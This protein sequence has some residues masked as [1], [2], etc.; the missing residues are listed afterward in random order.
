M[1]E[2][3]TS[4]RIVIVG[5]GGFGREMLDVIEAINSAG[6]NLEFLGFVDDGDVDVG[7][8]RHRQ[9]ALLGQ[10]EV[11][12]D[13]DAMYI[14]GIGNG[15]VRE[16][17]SARFDELG[18][19][20]A[21]LVH[22]SATVGGDTYAQ[23]GTVITAGSRLTTNIRLGRHVHV[24]LNTTIGHDASLDDFVT[25]NPGV[26]ISG[27]VTIG[28]RSTVGTGAVVLQGLAVA[29]DAFVG[30]GA[31]VTKNVEAGVTVAGVPARP[32]GGGR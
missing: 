21:T 24:N 28:A 26:S 30:A 1:I 16:M 31:A 5:A 25:L 10:T 15:R 6:G 9:A 12:V 23:P 4:G 11:L 32:L 2:P 27:N 29:A 13:L 17:L 8:L 14:L 7:L 3:T 22:P 20:A 18:I 19:A